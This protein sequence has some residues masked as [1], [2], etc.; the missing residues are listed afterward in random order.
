MRGVA[1]G[2]ELSDDPVVLEAFPNLMQAEMVQSMLEA[3][4]IRSMIRSMN[5]SAPL[6]Q[7]WDIAHRVFVMPADLEAARELLEK[8]G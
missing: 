3:E 2:A 6:T 8:A 4:G 7:S 5:G 1:T